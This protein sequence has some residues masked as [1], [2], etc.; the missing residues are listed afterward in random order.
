MLPETF[1]W[2]TWVNFF[3]LLKVESPIF[4]NV[5]MK[6]VYSNLSS[7]TLSNLFLNK[8]L[9]KIPGENRSTKKEFEET[10]HSNGK[11]ETSSQRAERY[12]QLR[13]YNEYAE[14]A[15]FHIIY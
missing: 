2:L 12:I 4:S 7:L 13:E 1:T 6:G 9:C 10:I 3:V 14:S 11:R 5:L 15:I 8:L